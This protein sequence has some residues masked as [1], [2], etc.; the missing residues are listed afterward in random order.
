MECLAKSLYQGGISI[1]HVIFTTYK[2]TQDGA[3]GDIA[4]EFAIWNQ[5]AEIWGRIYPGS[6][7]W[8]EP[9]IDK[10]L[11]LAREISDHDS[12]MQALVTGSLYLV[13][14]ALCLLEPKPSVRDAL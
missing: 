5:Y 14:G 1:Q 11:E 12:G 2:Q 7:I 3:I 13:G 4:H 8:K 9:T 10:A 6:N